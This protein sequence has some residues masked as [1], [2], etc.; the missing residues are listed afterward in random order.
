MEYTAEVLSQSPSSDVEGFDFPPGGRGE[1]LIRILVRPRGSAPW[2]GKFYS[3][4]GW[5]DINAVTGLE[6]WCEGPLLLV[7]SGGHPHYVNAADRSLAPELHVPVLHRV[8]SGEGVVVLADY[9]RVFAVNGFGLL[10]KISVSH[11][12]IHDLRLD[13]STVRGVGEDFRDTLVPFAIDL[14]GEVIERG[15][16]PDPPWP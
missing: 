2:V 3:M 1:P 9:T 14:S 7:V 16:D 12:G 11:D 13:G 5:F 8:R 6:V 10:W 15:F 4:G